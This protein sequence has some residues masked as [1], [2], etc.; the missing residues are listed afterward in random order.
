MHRAL[1]ETIVDCLDF[2]DPD[3]RLRTVEGRD[4]LIEEARKIS[5]G[6]FSG[7]YR[8]CKKSDLDRLF[9]RVRDELSPYRE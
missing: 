6:K 2:L 8:P 9:P 3:W 7:F 4:E 1:V 5:R